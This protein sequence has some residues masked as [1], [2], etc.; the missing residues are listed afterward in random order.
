VNPTQESSEPA[1]TSRA[2][3]PWLAQAA[4]ESVMILFSILLAFNIDNWREDSERARRLAEARVSLTQELRFNLKLL[5]ADNHLPHHSRLMNVYRDMMF[6]NTKDRADALF[7]RGIHPA[8]LRDAAWKSFLVSNVAGDLP[9]ELHARLAGIYGSQERLDFLHRTTI[10]SLLSP[11]GDRE[12]P[13]FVRDVIRTIAMYL[14][15]VVANEEGLREE[16]TSAIT[17]LEAASR[18]R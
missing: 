6:K 7:E 18:V 5:A 14:T 1:A 15:D 2:W 12:S 13:A 11:R 17:Q 4:F 8:P 9:F 3:G 16:Y 10:G